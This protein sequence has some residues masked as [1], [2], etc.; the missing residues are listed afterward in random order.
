MHCIPSA[1]FHSNLSLKLWGMQDRLNLSGFAVQATEP[2]VPG[3]A[4]V[5]KTVETGG[6]AQ[7]VTAKAREVTKPVPKDSAASSLITYRASVRK[8]A[9]HTCSLLTGTK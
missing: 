1:V 6:G 2:R 5:D 9:L 7:R 8:P 3:K 4:E